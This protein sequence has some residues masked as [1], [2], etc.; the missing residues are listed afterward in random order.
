MMGLPIVARDTLPPPQTAFS[1]LFLQAI[2]IPEDFMSQPVFPTP[3]QPTAFS[4]GLLFSD[5]TVLKT[6]ACVL[7]SCKKDQ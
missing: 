2:E 5:P 4:S 7:S 3:L 1:V 6:P